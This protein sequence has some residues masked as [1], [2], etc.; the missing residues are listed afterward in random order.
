M[1]RRNLEHEE[2]VALYQWAA[3]HYRK[4]PE[5]EWLLFAIPN[6]GKRPGAAGPW[7][8]AEGLKSGVWDNFLSVASRGC[9]GLYIEMKVGRNTLSFNQQTFKEWVAKKGYD[10]VVC[11][12]WQEAAREIVN[13]LGVEGVEI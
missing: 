6:A 1:K 9:N 13:Y 3:L 7:M 11:N 2:Q 4:M 12:S 8:A 10:A 5:L